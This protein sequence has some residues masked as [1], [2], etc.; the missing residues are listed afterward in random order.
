MTITP[1]DPNAKHLA[2]GEPPFYNDQS[3][4]F[5]FYK[6]G[7]IGIIGYSGVGDL[8]RTLSDF[9]QACAYFADSPPPA[10]IFILG[11]WNYANTG[12][13]SGMDTPAI[14]SQVQKF[15]GCDIGDSLRYIDGHTHC[16]VV[17]ERGESSPIGFMSGARGMI[18]SG[19]CLPM[20]GFTFVDSSRDNKLRVYHFHEHGAHAIGG[21]GHAAIKDC[22]T[23]TSSLHACTHLAELWLEADLT[24][25]SDKVELATE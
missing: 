15:K 7:N 14:R 25:P 9:K 22:V 13:S 19:K 11:H 3:N 24:P 17:Q 12:V 5:S 1:D 8:E 6:I 20:M 2:S 4:F 23:N 10:G 18:D 21:K 16:N